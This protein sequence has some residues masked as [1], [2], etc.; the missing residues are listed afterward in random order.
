MAKFHINVLQ[1]GPVKDFEFHLAPVMLFTG[2]SSLGKSYINFLA[3]Y[4]YYVFSSRRINEF[5]ENKLPTDI[6]KAES[7]ALTIKFDELRLWLEEDVA[8]FFRYLLNYPDVKCDVKF[9][10]DCE[11]TKIDFEYLEDSKN[12]VQNSDYYSAV[13]KVNGNGR[14]IVF[15]ESIKHISI[16]TFL[17]DAL[18]EILFGTRFLRSILL[19]PG[20]ASLMSSDY[21]TQ[22]QSS[23]TGMYDIFLRDNDRINADVLRKSSISGDEKDFADLVHNLIHGD[24]N[25]NKEGLKYTP[26]NEGTIPLEAAASSI[27]ELT[28]LLMW[29]LGGRIQ[30]Q[31]ICIEEPEAHLHPLMQV[32]IADLLAACINKGAYMQITTHSDYFLQRINQLIKLGRVK[33]DNEELFKKYCAEN[34]QSTLYYLDEQQI[35]AFYFHRENGETKIDKLEPGEEGLPLETFFGAIKYLSGE[36]EKIDELTGLCHND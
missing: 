26:E 27:K 24:L 12:K 9:I 23:K 10:F 11:K 28:P 3:Y 15:E 35:N 25:Y 30:N 20:R 14:K 1:L 31:S 34:E 19:P 29:M 4:C 2:A 8:K 5:I 33:K 36:D 22:S 32:D 7:F 6:N 13:F 18:M 16:I 17:R 21:S